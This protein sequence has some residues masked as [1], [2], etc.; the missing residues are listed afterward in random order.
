MGQPRVEGAMVAVMTHPSLRMAWVPSLRKWFCSA[1]WPP[2]KTV[3]FPLIGSAHSNS[4]PR[5]IN[6]AVMC[7]EK[8]SA[9]GSSPG[10]SPSRTPSRMVKLCTWPRGTPLKGECRPGVCVCVVCRM[11]VCGCVGK[12]MTKPR[13]IGGAPRVPSM[14]QPWCQPS[15]YT[16]V[17]AEPSQGTSPEGMQLNPGN[18]HTHETRVSHPPPPRDKHY[19]QKN[20]NDR[21]RTPQGDLAAEARVR[22]ADQALGQRQRSRLVEQVC[23]KKKSLV[24]NKERSGL[25]EALHV[26][27][28]CQLP[29]TCGRRKVRISSG[30]NPLLSSKLA[31]KA[32]FVTRKVS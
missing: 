2:G 18:L 31:Q 16:K 6:W 8:G 9:R 22:F 27:V 32:T 3:R 7:G 13:L 29:S 12:A 25:A 14:C 15:G 30:R 17:V 21:W 23:K 5:S 4:R 20:E 24:V 1:R 11:G 19:I 10:T 28:I 26:P